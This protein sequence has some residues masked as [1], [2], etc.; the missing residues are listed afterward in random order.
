MSVKV[1]TVY[2]PCP[3]EINDLKLALTD[4][5]HETPQDK[6]IGGFAGPNEV[7]QILVDSA[8][9]QTALG[10]LA[11]LFG[12][13]FALSFSTELG[14]QVATDVWKNRANY[15]EAMK[16]ASAAPFKR[17][18]ESLA[19]LRR[20]K[21]T[22]TVSIEVPN[23]VRNASIV[24][25]SE[26]PEEVAWQM[27]LTILHTEEVLEV[28]REV[29]LFADPGGKTNPDLSIVL[30][31]LP[32]G[33]MKVLGRTIKKQ[34]ES[35]RTTASLH[36]STG[37]IPSIAETPEAVESEKVTRKNRIDGQVRDAGWIYSNQG[38]SGVDG[39]QFG[40]DIFLSHRSCDKIWVERLGKALQE[41]GIRVWLDRNEIRPG[42]L[43]AEALERGL[44]AS[45]SVGLVVTPE[46]VESGWVREEYYRAL[47]LVMG[48]RLQLIPI[49]LRT[50]ELP[51]FLGGRNHV[52]FRNE[53][54][55][56]QAVDRLIWPGITGNQICFF[57]VHS[58]GGVVWRDLGEEVSSRGFDFSAS[59][60]IEYAPKN[61]QQLLDGKTKVVVVLDVFEDWPSKS[62]PG[63]E[64]S[65]YW[66]V[67]SEL[68]PSRDVLIVLYQHPD[69]I[70]DS[71]SRLPSD[72]LAEMQR[73]FTIPRSYDDNAF[74]QRCTPLPEQRR[75]LHESFERVMKQVQREFLR[76][77]RDAVQG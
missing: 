32:T 34:R 37:P 40:F 33:D 51:G 45:R 68:R 24:I 52:D 7:V 46:S 26:D 15:A 72:V 9:W 2:E 21:Q 6:R 22:T 41:R 54:E 73:F 61:V 59:D 50:S 71:D 16:R 66:K 43:F 44:E 1:A 48:R 36:C 64:P 39:K 31:I 74:A 57:G 19:A 29:V 56:E 60:Y 77:S 23:S 75:M 28:V 70:K 10:G 25:T 3:T 5:F 8:T 55:F 49:L 58:I 27:S 14:K 47:S 65:D 42:D 67:V 62:T 30:E 76:R 18:V 53:H 38:T 63:R 20:K 11:L 35:C 4:V 69:A 17:L 13:S 12:G